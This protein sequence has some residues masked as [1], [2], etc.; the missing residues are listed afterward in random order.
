MVIYDMIVSHLV[1]FHYET[2]IR[3]VMDINTVTGSA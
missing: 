3:F 2:T 1:R